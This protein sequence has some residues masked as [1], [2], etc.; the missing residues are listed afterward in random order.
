MEQSFEQKELVDFLSRAQQKMAD[1]ALQA[2]RMY[3]RGQSPRA[4]IELGLELR[5]AVGL[6]GRYAAQM[7]LFDAEDQEECDCKG[8]LEGQL[9]LRQLTEIAQ[10]LSG[11]ADLLCY[12][13][14]RLKKLC[15]TLGSSASSGVRF[16][17]PATM[18]SVVSS[19]PNILNV[20]QAIT[21]IYARLGQTA[22]ELWIIDGGR[23]RTDLYKPGA[24]DH[25]E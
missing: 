14:V 22:R 20:Q 17:I 9:T 16:P 23:A 18:V 13:V 1:L 15:V 4:E 2:G 3:R 11:R 5:M 12:P 19:D 21:D 24:R 10:H 8:C 6:V 7:K 25:F